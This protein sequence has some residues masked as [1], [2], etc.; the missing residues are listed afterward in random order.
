MTFNTIDCQL[1]FEGLQLEISQ[2][3]SNIRVP[4]LA[5]RY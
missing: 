1:V 5:I 2:I 4:E 3:A